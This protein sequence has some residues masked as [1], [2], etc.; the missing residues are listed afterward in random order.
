[1]IFAFILF[2]FF[3]FFSFF[4]FALYC[5]VK[6]VQ[7]HRGH[8]SSIAVVCF[9]SFC[10]TFARNMGSLYGF[11]WQI[12]DTLYLPV[13]GM[14]DGASP[15]SCTWLRFPSF[16]LG[17]LMFCDGNFMVYDCCTVGKYTRVA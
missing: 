6:K 14:I 3:F 9:N 1:M 12:P 11:R 7:R 8:N 5:Y 15:V 10:F 17:C 4:W 2:Y 16:S 13:A